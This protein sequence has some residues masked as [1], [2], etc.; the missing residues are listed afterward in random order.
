MPEFVPHGY[1]SVRDAADRLGC[2]LFLSEWM[3]EVLGAEWI[4]Q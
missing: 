2:K 4:N 3:S 1:V